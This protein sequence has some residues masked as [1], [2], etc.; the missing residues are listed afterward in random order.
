MSFWSD[1]PHMTYFQ[2]ITSWFSG[3]RLPSVLPMTAKMVPYSS[4]IRSLD[5]NGMHLNIQ[6][7]SHENVHE[8]NSFL[9]RHFYDNDIK[10]QKNYHTLTLYEM[11]YSR[12]IYGMEIRLADESN[13]LI[14]F[15][16]A[17]K[18]GEYNSI[19]ISLVMDLCVHQTFR[20]QGIANILLRYLY[21]ASY[22]LPKQT[23][24]HLFQIDKITIAPPIPFISKNIIYGRKVK[25]VKEFVQR[26][27][28]SEEFYQIWKSTQLAKNPQTVWIE[29]SGLDLTHIYMYSSYSAKVILR[30]LYEVDENNTPG[31]EVLFYQGTNVD[32]LL[33]G[34][35]FGWF[36]S[37]EKIS[38][39][40]TAQGIT[41]TYAFHLDY[42]SPSTR[43]I[44]FL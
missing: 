23:L 10:F 43:P 28:F 17:R 11:I 8:Y 27:K 16:F 12:Q 26:G 36:E 40:W 25:Q 24:V 32:D 30:H 35:E 15:T 5:Y 38:P 18:I 21:S 9:K 4:I 14:G 20:G 3:P 19:P 34:T 44:I 42:G 7:V 37:K 29:S 33:D 39:Q 22:N 6:P 2:T 41:G 31:A 1:A 13:G